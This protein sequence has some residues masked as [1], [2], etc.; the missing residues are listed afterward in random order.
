MEDVLPS[1]G[2][3]WCG[4]GRPPTAAYKETK[5]QQRATGVGGVR[6][7]H[8]A[9]FRA[10]ATLNVHIA[11]RILNLAERM[12][13]SAQT[14]LIYSVLTSI[15][16]AIPAHALARRY[17]DLALEGATLAA[18]PGISSQV[19]LFVSL[20][21]GGLGDWTSCIERVAQAEALARE[22][23]DVRRAEECMVISGYLHLHT[24]DITG[25]QKFYEAAATSARKRGDRQTTSWGLLGMARVM[26]V[27]GRPESALAALAEAAPSVT[28]S[29][30]GIEL[31]GI[32]ALAHLRTRQFEQAWQAA[33][34]G[35]RLLRESRPVSLT[36]LTGSAGVTETLIALWVHARGGVA[37]DRADVLKR[38]ARRALGLLGQFARIFPI[39]RARWHLQRGHYA[40]ADGRSAAALECWQK[41]A[42]AAA[43]M[44]MP[45]DE[46]LAWLE[47]SRHGAGAPAALARAHAE[48]LFEKLGAAEP[49]PPYPTFG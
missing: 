28:D 5:A 14:A 45:L 37:V 17:R 41:S 20:Y 3:P 32:N 49:A 48:A 43:A 38:E 22:I 42:D 16:G 29:L 18:E 26:L 7:A 36:T 11:L 30:G 34:A 23:G 4:V 10:D 15:A 44:S 39:G 8:I 12:H 13:H 33:R 9:W 1:A 25:A 19:L 6:Y 46:A 40:L 27:L 21:Q 47:I 31:H 35:L 24:G 2:D